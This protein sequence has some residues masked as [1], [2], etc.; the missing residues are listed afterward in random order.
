MLWNIRDEK[1]CAD[2]VNQKSATDWADDPKSVC[3][4]RK[5]EHEK[6]KKLCDFAVVY[7]VAGGIPCTTRASDYGKCQKRDSARK[8]DCR[9]KDNYWII[10]DK[11][12][13]SRELSALHV[14]RKL[15]VAYTGY[16][17]SPHFLELFE[18]LTGIMAGIIVF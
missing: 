16:R 10:N 5:K 7:A 15:R 2:Q 9:R 6:A 13:A 18:P 8:C 14:N 11:N 3:G 4:H 17:P 12:P 1:I